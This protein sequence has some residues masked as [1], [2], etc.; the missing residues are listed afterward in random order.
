MALVPL[1]LLPVCIGIGLLMQRPLARL[2]Q[3]QT[4]ESAQRQGLLIEVV[5]GAEGV[6]AQGGEWR[7]GTLWQRMTRE[8]ADYG[9]RIVFFG[10]E[11][12]E[13]EMFDPASG[14]RLEGLKHMV[15]YPAN[16]FVTSKDTMFDAIKEIQD[17]LNRHG[18]A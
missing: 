1:C 8:L 9:Y 12:E 6:K 13:M 7:F 15:I 14:G 10:D 4:D 3:Q 2:Q 5:H 17:T 16:I 18:S 11:I